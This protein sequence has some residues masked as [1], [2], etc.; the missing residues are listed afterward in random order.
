MN[1][2]LDYQI[3]RD[4]QQIVGGPHFRDMIVLLDEYCVSE[5]ENGCGKYLDLI[6]E[7]LKSQE[8]PILNKL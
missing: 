4:Y 8:I 1:R 5:F 3:T 6:I 2:S 7:R